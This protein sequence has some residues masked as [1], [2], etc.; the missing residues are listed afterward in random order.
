M[1]FSIILCSLPKC[2]FPSYFPH[3]LLIHTKECVKGCQR[4]EVICP[5]QP[6]LESLPLLLSLMI[7]CWLTGI[8]KLK[9]SFNGFYFTHLGL[10]IAKYFVELRQ[11]KNWNLGNWNGIDF[12]GAIF[13]P[14]LWLL[15]NFRN[16]EK[17]QA[18]KGNAVL[19]REAKGNKY[20]VQ[21]TYSGLWRTW[22]EPSGFWGLSWKHRVLWSFLWWASQPREYRTRHLKEGR[23]RMSGATI[24]YIKKEKNK[25]CWI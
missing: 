12:C 1:N 15:I 8:C 6:C 23:T 14:I 20:P 5:K 11:P 9:L 18:Y 2:H 21:G 17:Q 13:C 3:I 4:D 10:F 22:S 25:C 7:L 24:N 19:R 16:A